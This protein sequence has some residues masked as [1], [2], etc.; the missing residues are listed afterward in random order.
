MYDRRALVSTDPRKMHEQL[1]LSEA[2]HADETVLQ[3]LH[4]KGKK[5][6][7]RFKNVDLLQRKNK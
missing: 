2:I 7:G 5:G 3:V 1:L 4:E 6:N